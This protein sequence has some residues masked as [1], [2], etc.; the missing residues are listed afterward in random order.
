M[1][2]DNNIYSSQLARYQSGPESPTNV[3]QQKRV[4]TITYND[5]MK[6]QIQLDSKKIN[7]INAKFPKDP[8]PIKTFVEI[9]KLENVVATVSIPSGDNSQI[10]ILDINMGDNQIY[11]LTQGGSKS[12]KRGG[13]RK[14]RVSTRRGGGRKSRRRHNYI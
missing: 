2:Y 14:S 10:S 7:E 11:T 8:L 1:N 6:K 3:K 5:E 13:G 12:T 4:I 9:A